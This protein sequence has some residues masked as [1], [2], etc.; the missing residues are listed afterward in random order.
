MST[1][2]KPKA[3]KAKLDL[4]KQKAELVLNTSLN[5]FT[6]FFASTYFVVGTPPP[7]PAPPVDQAKL[8]ADNDALQAAINAAA[9]GGKKATTAKNHAKEVVVVDLEQIA[10]YVSANSKGDMNA[11]LSS[12]F[13]PAASTKT[14]TPPVSET[15]KKIVPGAKSGE[16]DVT[17]MKFPKASAYEIRCGVSGAGGTMPTNWTTIPVTSVRSAATVPNL[18]P[19]LLYVFQARAVVNGGYSDY[20]DP[21][22]RI[23]V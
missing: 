12:G 15:I 1:T 17:L 4:R 20:G 7:A 21:I 3:I 23:A 13:T 18:T 2:V 16:M 22:A 6:N 11:F 14:K 5:V 19:G 8:K 9:T 10:A